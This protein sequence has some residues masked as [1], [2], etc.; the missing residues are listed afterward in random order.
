MNTARRPL[1]ETPAREDKKKRPV[2][3]PRAERPIMRDPD[4]AAKALERVRGER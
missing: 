4:A 2:G 3:L 1:R